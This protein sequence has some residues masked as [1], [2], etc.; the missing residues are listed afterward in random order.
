MSIKINS[1]R[2]L[3]DPKKIIGYV[4]FNLIK[5]KMFFND[6]PVIR[7]NEGG[8]FVASPSRA[9]KNKEGE[10]K[11]S[12][13]WGFIDR[14]YSEVFQEKIMMELEDF[15]RE[16]PQQQS[17]QPQ[18]TEEQVPQTEDDLPF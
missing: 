7:K 8:F 16:N 1:Y 3:K 12:Q 6:C 4:S 13:Y 11:Y 10:D 9:Y 2:A 5:L 14:G 18:Q 15:W 17:S